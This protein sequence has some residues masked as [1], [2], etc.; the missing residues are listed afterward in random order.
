[1]WPRQCHALNAASALTTTMWR[2]WRLWAQPT[3]CP[4]TPVKAEEFYRSCLKHDPHNVEALAFVKQANARAKRHWISKAS[5]NLSFISNTARDRFAP[6]TAMEPGHGVTPQANPNA[7]RTHRRQINSRMVLQV[8]GSR[9]H[10][11]VCH[12]SKKI[13]ARGSTPAG[14]RGL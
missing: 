6:S 12:R 1:M 7:T 3:R 2:H 9:R 5:T 11:R 8:L 14:R 10:I 13:I 4:A